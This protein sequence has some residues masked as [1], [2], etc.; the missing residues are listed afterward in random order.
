MASAS[1][2]EIFKVR[3]AMNAGLA[4]TISQGVKRA[5]ATQLGSS[6]CRDKQMVVALSIM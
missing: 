6:Y 4:S 5:T 1:A 2:G 3:N